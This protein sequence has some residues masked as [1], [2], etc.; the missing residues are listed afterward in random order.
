[1]RVDVPT[2]HFL[3]STFVQFFTSSD[4]MFIG[5]Q[6]GSTFTV[7][8]Q[9]A[10][11][12]DMYGYAHFGNSAGNVGTNILDDMGTAPGA[13]GFTP[14]LAAGSYTFW[15]QQGT[16]GGTTYQLNFDVFR[17]GDYNGNGQVDAADYTVWRNT[18]GSTTDLRA[19]GTGPGGVPDQVINQLDYMFWKQKYSDD[20]SN[21]A[22]ANEHPTVPEPTTVLLAFPV[23]I[24]TYASLRQRLTHRTLLKHCR[25]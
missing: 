1:L 13:I 17:P 4:V 7:T 6:Q 12:G 9:E 18:L 2:S 15:L 20:T 22:I 5:V 8:P 16:A 24:I 25:Q 23:I 11:A 19:D 14:P 21:G 10:A 3:R